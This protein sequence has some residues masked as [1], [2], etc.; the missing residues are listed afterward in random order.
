ML[1]Y[2]KNEKIHANPP[3]IRTY[4]KWN[5]ENEVDN[6]ISSLKHQNIIGS[7]QTGRTGLGARKYKPFGL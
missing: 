5:A 1:K 2:S 4:R 7:T 6:A 3:E